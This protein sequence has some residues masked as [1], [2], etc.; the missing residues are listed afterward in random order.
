MILL[1]FGVPAYARARRSDPCHKVHQR[2]GEEAKANLESLKRLIV[3]PVL[4]EGARTGSVKVET[5][6][7]KRQITVESEK[8]TYV[9]ELTDDPN[10]TYPA[11]GLPEVIMKNGRRFA[12]VT[13]YW[14]HALENVELAQG[15]VRS[16]IRTDLHPHVPRDSTSVS[17]LSFPQRDALSALVG[18]E[19][20]KGFWRGLFLPVGMGK[21][22]ISAKYVQALWNYNHQVGAKGWKKKP[23][24]IFAVENNYILDRTAETFARELGL[25]KISKVYGLNDK[26]DFD[27]N[28]DMIAITR[29]SYFLRKERI[30]ELMQADPEQPWILIFDEAHHVEKDDGQF[31]KIFDDLK[32]IMDHRH[33][34][35]LLSSFFGFRDKKLMTTQLN[36]N[37]FGSFLNREEA[38][39]LSRGER[40]AELCRAQ[41]F[42]GM[43]FGYLS[44]L[45]GLEVVRHVGDLETSEILGG[46][47][48]EDDVR[49]VRI[50]PSLLKDV[51]DRVEDNRLYKVPDRG[52]FFVDTTARAD[53]YA[54]ELSELLGEEVRVIHS[55]PTSDPETFDWFSDKGK[56]DTSKDRK[57]HKYVVVVDIF[58]EGVDITSINLVVLLRQYGDNPAGFA[59][60]IQNLGRASRNHG[61]EDQFKPGFRAIDYSGATRWLR[62]GLAQV[63]IEPMREGGD[64]AKGYRPHITVDQRVMTPLVFQQQYFQLFPEEATFNALYPEFEPDVFKEEIVPVLRQWA[65]N[66]GI[67]NWARDYSPREFVLRLARALPE[68]PGKNELI[69]RFED[70]QTYEW[71]Y[72]DGRQA[73]MRL[74]PA[75]KIY[76]AI[77]EI[78]ALFHVT[79]QGRSLRLLELN[80]PSGMEKFLEAL[81]PMDR[82]LSDPKEI[83][84]FLSERK[85]ALPLLM[86]TARGMKGLRQK[87]ILIKEALLELARRIP[88]CPER[89]ARIAEMESTEGWLW[90]RQDGFREEK[91]SA[92][93]KAELSRS[94][95]ARLWG[96]NRV[97]RSWR[98]IAWLW[99]QAHPEAQV[100]L[101]KIHELE[102]AERLL[103]L[104]NPVPTAPVLDSKKLE[105]FRD[106]ERGA[107]PIVSERYREF[108]MER[109]TV[110]FGPKRLSLELARRLPNS[111]EKDQLLL[112]LENPKLYDW[113]GS[114]GA[115]LKPDSATATSSERLYKALHA[116]AIC[117][118]NAYPDA[119]IDP[120]SVHTSAGVEALLD[121]FSPGFV[122][123][124][125]TS[126]GL[127][128]F[129]ESGAHDFLA[130]LAES[131]LAIRK[132][133]FNES[134]GP[135]S[136]TLLLAQKLPK[137]EEK[138]L[139]L[140]AMKKDE[141]WGWT[142]SDGAGTSARAIRREYRALLAIAHIQNKY[143]SK[144]VD[145]E[146]FD[147]REL[148]ELA[149]AL[150]DR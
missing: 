124:P 45:H 87:D 122:I 55:R 148:E 137:S 94:E 3:L 110:D 81:V 61:R 50:Y 109:F 125:I 1:T 95:L 7:A 34:A 111:K 19:S 47:T 144:T 67:S 101:A 106:L 18:M 140:K 57:Q 142:A 108:G 35:L 22:I 4:E 82:P 130:G 12:R 9:F 72:G 115:N 128:R 8:G 143:G 38:L 120:A 98:S 77:H 104:L 112:D 92:A 43:Q 28:S 44:P 39:A 63:M 78:A 58:K 24:I 42:R 69:A 141:I 20:K 56:F 114:D 134:F 135:K 68:L 49:R 66:M 2:T 80:S 32:P 138:K 96:F 15:Q 107:A 14:K 70:P 97:Y 13:L 146:R 60:L 86:S 5:N 116:I 74:A 26:E 79:P 6:E 33:R 36:G 132:S 89:D 11:I 64:H 102:E 133:D 139:L 52:I 76:Q 59:N 21:T 65:M 131:E 99:N 23:K 145:T 103:L 85:G 149:E 75:Q 100:D 10:Q 25:K 119:G 37:V 117:M 118:K 27:L 30:H 126:K 62:E 93:E 150:L 17:T 90:S 51:A 84:T 54:N 40:L 83:Q 31:S 127:S 48:L 73:Q 91:L 123:P 16:A 53:A 29:S 105:V 88:Q 121:M 113:I 41:Y 71:L 136:A 46:T 129:V 147:A